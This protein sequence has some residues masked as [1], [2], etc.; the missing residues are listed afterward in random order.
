VVCIGAITFLGNSADTKFSS[1][2]S[3]LG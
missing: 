1:V 2:G 3:Q